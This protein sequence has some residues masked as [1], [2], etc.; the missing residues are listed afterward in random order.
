MG[1]SPYFMVYGA[2]AV[3]PADIAFISPRVKTL[4]KTGLTKH[5]NSTSTALKN[6]GL[7]PVYVQLII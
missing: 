7:T 4:M 3:L 2:E 1:A 5:V 6:D